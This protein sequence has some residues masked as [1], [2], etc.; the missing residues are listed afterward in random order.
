MYLGI[1]KE[2]NGE[3]RL[4]REEG[5]KLQSENEINN[6]INVFKTKQ[7]KQKPEPSVNLVTRNWMLSSSP[8]PCVYVNHIH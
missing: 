2:G 5:Q 6:Y 4:G 8:L 1:V 3:A 7:N